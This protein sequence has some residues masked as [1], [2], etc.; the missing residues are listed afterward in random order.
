[1]GRNSFNMGQYKG[2]E[3]EYETGE[4]QSKSKGAIALVV[5]LVILVLAL[6]ALAITFGILWSQERN[7]P[8][9]ATTELPPTPTTESPKPPEVE[10]ER[11]DCYPEA[12]GGVDLA[13]QEK[14]EA[15]GCIWSPSTM[16]GAPS[17]FYGTNV[18]RKQL[19]EPEDTD[20]GYKVKLSS[21]DQTKRRLKRDVVEED[22]NPDVD[23]LV[24]EVQ[25]L[26]DNLLRFQIYDEGD[27]RYRVP[28]PLNLK[29]TRASNPTYAVEITSTDPFQFKIIRKSTGKTLWDTSVGSFVFQDQFIQI[30]TKL[31]S[32]N[33]YGFGEN[34]HQSFKHDLNYKT[35]PMFSRDQPTQGGGSTQNH[36]GVHPFYT[37]LEDNDGN[38][39]GV[40]LLNS[41]AMDYTLSPAPM[42]TY[43]TIGGV[44]D[45]YMFLGP[46]PENVVQQYT[47]LIGRPY[48]PPY[49][50][51]GF[52]LCKYG[53]NNI[54]TVKEVV[55]RTRRYNIPHDVQYVDIDHMDERKDFTIDHVNFPGLREYFDQLRE[56]G[57]RTITILDPALI[58]NETNYEPYELM[59]ETDSF[60]QWPEDPPIPEMDKAWIGGDKNY[61][62]GYVWP[63][64][65]VAIPDFM[66]NTTHKAWSHLI[67]KHFNHSLR[68]DGLWIDM[69]EIA[70]FD[71]N[72][73]RPWNWPEKDKPYWNLICPNNKWDDPPYRTKAAF[74]WDNN[75][76]ME[77]LSMKTICMVGLQGNSLEYRQYDTHSLYGWSQTKPTLDALR[78]AHGG[79]KRGLV[80][81]RSTYPG[82]GA[83][84]GHWLGDNASKWKDLHESVIGMLEFNLF[85]IPYIGADICGFFENSNAELCKRWMQLGAFYTFSRNHNGNDFRPQDPGYFGDEVARMSR[86]VLETRYRFLPYLY[87]LFYYA[88]SRGDTVIRPLMHE[89]PNDANTWSIDRQFLWGGGLLISP[90]LEE[91]QSIIDMYLPKGLWY[92]Y[93]TGA[94]IKTGEGTNTT[95]EVNSLSPIP[96]HLRG[97]VIFPLQEPAVTTT[98]SRKN[99]FSLLVALD[100]NGQASG[101]L[102]WDDGESIEPL[103]KDEYSY[104]E[105]VA[106]ENTLTVTIVKSY[107]PDIET[108]IMDTVHILGVSGNGIRVTLNGGD[109]NDVILETPEH[110]GGNN[111]VVNTKVLKITRM[112]HPMSNN[113]TITW[114]TGEEGSES[115]IDC[116]PEFEK[117]PQW[118]SK[119]ICDSKAAC[120]WDD[121]SNTVQ[122]IPKCYIS[123]PNYGYKFV[124][125]NKTNHGYDIRLQ[126]RNAVDTLYQEDIK[127]ITLR[128]EFRGNSI[129][130]LKF[131][132]HS[133]ARYEVPVDIS[134]PSEPGR[135]WLLEFKITNQDPFNFQ[136]IRKSTG[137]VIW[138]TGVGGFTFADKF[139]QIST[140]IPSKNVYGFG[141]NL[142]TDFKHDM[143]FRTWPIW[144]RDQPPNDVGMNLYGTYPYYTCIEDDGLSHGVFLLNSNAQDY[145]FTPLPKLTYRAIGGVF[146]FYFFAGPSQNSVLEQFTGVI[147]RPYM[148]PY[149]ALGF[150]LCKYGYN[151]I[152]NLQAAVERTRQ[153]EIPHDVQY[154]DIDHMEAAKDF[155]VD[156]MNFPG[157]NDYFKE[158]QSGGM[159]IIIILDPA[160]TTNA[161]DY[162]P[163][164]LGLE[165]DIYIKWPEERIPQEDFVVTNSSAMLGYVWPQGKTVFP[166]FFLNRTEVVW[167]DLIVKHH[168]QKLVFDGLW[169]DMNEPANFGTNEDKPWNWPVGEPAWSLKCPDDEDPPYM[170]RAAYH[171]DYNDNTKKGRLSDKTLCLIA[172]QKDGQYDHYDVHNLYGHSQIKPTLNAIRKAVGD[173]KR[174]LV[175][176]R[177]AFPGSGAMA[178]HWLGDNDANWN[179][180][181]YSIIGM[182]EFNLFGIPYVGADICGF[183]NTPTPELCGRWMQLGAFYPYSRN[184]NHESPPPQDPGYFGEEVA[185]MSREALETRYSLLPYLYTLFERAHT[186]GSA[187]VRG[188]MYEW[189]DDK[190]ALA[191]DEQFMWGPSLLISPILYEKQ[192]YLKLYVPK[193]RWYDFYS[194]GVMPYS[195]DFYSM[196]VNST[197]K[198]PLHIRGGSILPTQ[199]PANNTHFSRM[200]TFGLKVALSDWD[201]ALDGMASGQLMW[202][203]GQS[204]DTF[205]KGNYYHA[206]FTSERKQKNVKM[207]IQHNGLS[208]MDALRLSSIDV[209]GVRNSYPPQF[210]YINNTQEHKNFTYDADNQVLHIADLDL[211]MGYDFEVSWKRDKLTTQDEAERLDCFP[212]AFSHENDVGQ[213]KCKA[214][215]CIWEKNTDIYRVPWCYL[216]RLDYGYTETDR[217]PTTNPTGTIYRLERKSNMSMFG[218]DIDVINLK[219]EETTDTMMRFKFFDPNENRYEVP[220][221]LNIPA[222]SATNPLY[223]YEA[224]T[225]NN[226]FSL[227]I[228]RKSTGNVIW[229]MGIGGF[230]F[231]NQFLQIA[232]R[233]P[234]TNVYGFGENRHFSFRHD[235]DFQTWPMFARDQAPGWGDYGNLYGVHPFYTCVED[236]DGNTHG[237]L[238]LN[239]NAMEYKF[240]PG[241]GLI[242]RTIG[243]I[244]D[245]FVFMGPSPEQVTQQ[246][247]QLIG[248]PYMPPYWSLGFQLCRYGYNHIDN[249]KAAVQRTID[250]GI[251]FDVQYG[252]IDH[253]EERMDFTYDK[254]NFAGLPEYIRDIQSKG[255]RFII[256]L[257]PAIISNVTGYVPYEDGLDKDVW[258]KWPTGTAPNDTFHIDDNMKGY[259]WPKGPTVFPD[260]FKPA[261]KD[262]WKEQCQ[263]HHDEIPFDGLWIDMNEPAN[264][265]TNDERPFNWPEKDIPYWSL[266]CATNNLDDPPYK[267]RAVFG[268]RLSEK[269]LCMVGLSEGGLTQYDVH[270]LYGWSQS[271]PTLTALRSSLTGERGMVISRSTYPSSGRY[272]GHWLGD[273]ES[274]WSDLYDSI[275]GMLEFNLF[276]VPYIGA[277]ICGFFAE[278][279]PELCQRWMQLGAFYTFSR[280]HNGLNNRAQDPAAFGPAVA[281]SSKKALEVRYTLLPYLYTLFYE[282]N[283]NGGTVI[284]P[285]M[286]EFTQD[287]TTLGID[288]QFLWGPSVLI[289]PVLEQGKTDVSGYLP[290]SRWFDYY[291]GKEEDNVGRY[292]TFAAPLDH[293]PVHIRGGYIIPTQLPANNTHFS[294]LNPMGAIVAPD[295]K[296]EANGK[297]FWDDGTTIDTVDN[298]K[299]YLASFLYSSN[300]FE[301]NIN[302]TTTIPTVN[303]EYLRVFGIQ[304]IPTNMQINTNIP[305]DIFEYD[306][307]TKELYIQ[308]LN[309]T[310][311][312]NI[313]ITWD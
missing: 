227:K 216:P 73:V 138:D 289:T 131:F 161:T 83:H 72:R 8:E 209:M 213:S 118:L 12:G 181:R 108:L 184:H 220:I 212:E 4:K 191:I 244:L 203:D 35:W 91:G 283:Q 36:Y 264:F 281:E 265:G 30:A 304:N 125:Q 197:T 79:T 16:P 143:N 104:F 77:R 31:P 26:E 292:V 166:D 297:L 13:T 145:S 9:Q 231:G 193:G 172:K 159:K 126:K 192:T 22:D 167:T 85:G 66:K 44:L 288:R 136:I 102:Y 5:I 48:M 93:Y 99:P 33:I 15:R 82:S 115:R 196:E 51:L 195:G 259:V 52:Q 205:E 303:F 274:K 243:G 139:L 269:T 7:K 37:C 250:A 238:L 122:G 282:V 235:L 74:N 248:K 254:V 20:L 43:R 296:N 217:N 58:V 165:N 168:N 152:S 10:T 39:H 28:I 94:L 64:G 98:L 210:I 182:L 92:D 211:S 261:T 301:M 207:S 170:T 95:F 149:W 144:G 199:E 183:F 75:D 124:S 129:V 134:L 3:Y 14:C 260:Y 114:K 86:E 153:Y 299:Y 6:L 50:S 21:S 106:K 201:D 214:R 89:F 275:I 245:F 116:C 266:K 11:I 38:S 221:P 277:D 285:V 268:P 141:E 117:N 158:L 236:E 53:Y 109:H 206:V 34:V 295:S 178:G 228:K 42:L 173:D 123:S 29:N 2:G 78:E 127:D 241:P 157:L 156:D 242:Y 160:F 23:P 150:Q 67:K 194:G 226:V 147:G 1:M 308:D 219:V 45:F 239:S 188:I 306:S 298:D 47:Q 177:S 151:N 202:D 162:E 290:N 69:N 175:V 312:S 112:N 190:E 229:D 240:Q 101:D 163:Y 218:G 293:I 54:E 63:K 169:I 24:F 307:D 61:M 271:E 137:T 132:D 107:I 311:S 284:R 46:T 96:L 309:H 76:Q 140:R 278:A 179:D 57:M 103:S 155:T 174:S 286:H 113:L 180:L 18:G 56:Q 49:W 71:T 262:W 215:G 70:S 19:G 224:A 128:V 55:D 198:I 200:N 223:E 234:S 121:T 276:G 27:T 253:F 280:N 62:I 258:I 142:H 270:N 305:H 185:R 176:T 97:G 291:T 90:I 252:D 146:D 255:M 256:I 41:N 186:T 189:P 164:E 302:H 249:M 246:Y 171:F 17:C 257:D 247:H 65:P 100:D 222:G 294:R 148:P 279:T 233:L 68:F 135:S 300:S 25:M 225:E 130:R 88:N 60:I 263:A 81:S 204:I 40:F 119:D 133:N 105:F 32:E 208:N 313:K 267:P 84:A 111:V 251:P 237:I 110:P 80:I 287:R 59:K 187:V 120:T 230:T 154:A 273:N 232:T 310:M 272:A 87:T